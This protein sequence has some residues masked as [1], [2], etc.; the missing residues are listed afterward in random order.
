MG[1]RVTIQYSIDI[2]DLPAEV[3]RLMSHATAELEKLKDVDWKLDFLSMSM[4][5]NIE[6]V[7]ASL[8]TTDQI[9]EDVESIITGYLQYKTGATAEPVSPSNTPLSNMEEKIAAFKNA[10]P[11]MPMGS[12]DEVTD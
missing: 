2:D 9:L 10:L 4:L 6:G 3:G 1:Q 8:G 7:R 11:P 12:P 5:E